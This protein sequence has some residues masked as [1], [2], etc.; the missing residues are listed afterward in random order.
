MNEEKKKSRS[1]IS[2]HKKAE[3]RYRALFE[4]ASDGILSLTLSGKIVAVNESFARMHGYSI[5]EILDMSLQ[6]LDTPETLKLVT[7]R[8]RRILAGE[9]L[10]FEVE[11]Y[12]KDGHIF[13]LEVVA[14]LISV[15]NEKL[16]VAFHRDITDRNKIIEDLKQSEETL[17]LTQEVSQTGSW[18][19]DTNTNMLTWSKEVYKIFGTN[20]KKTP[21]YKEFLKTIHP[22]DSGRVIK[23]IE[24][25]LKENKEFDIEYRIVITDN[26]IRY[27]HAKGRTLF[28]SDNKPFRMLGLINDITER[29]KAD[30]KMEGKNI[31]LREVLEQLEIEK[32]NL[33]KNI[34]DNINQLILPS[35]KTFKPG[36]VSSRQI[37]ML[38][39]NLE[40]IASSFG[41]KVTDK[42]FRLTPKEIELCNMISSDFT[43]KDIA[44]HLNLSVQTVEK[45]R[46]NIRKKLGIVNKKVNLQTYL[47]D[48]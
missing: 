37:N 20:T 6:V 30:E 4:K 12:H 17:R 32:I 9:T 28:D 10:T 19:W 18:V 22:E 26:K 43:N 39:K 24:V 16:V 42:K 5:K 11:H 14:N 41:K 8:M 47:Q 23:A 7:E 25:C 33:Q 38:E 40:N 1:D 27:V 2:E 15:G 21:S 46:K 48:L 31:A 44:D 34:Q 3:A 13:P 29:K 45:H 36:R 35:L